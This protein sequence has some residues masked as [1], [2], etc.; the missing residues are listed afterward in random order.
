M[1]SNFEKPKTEPINSFLENF[2]KKIQGLKEKEEEEMRKK[3][4]EGLTGSVHLRGLNP[5]EL[6]MEDAVIYEKFKKLDLTRKEYEEWRQNIVKDIEARAPQEPIELSGRLEFFDKDSRHI[7]MQYIGNKIGNWENWQKRKEQ[8][9]SFRKE[10]S[11]LKNQEIE[12][13]ERKE[14]YDPHLVT[15]LN[16][17]KLTPEDREIFEKFKAGT[18]KESSEEFRNYRQE[19]FQECQEHFLYEL[20]RHKKLGEFIKKAR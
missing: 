16:V 7:F 5:E 9:S 2:H 14:K 17:Q 8:L 1:E 10:I 18:L 6:T 19:I 20:S 13:M 12:K 11:R 3:E 4:A 15:I